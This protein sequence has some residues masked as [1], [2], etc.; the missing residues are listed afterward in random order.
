M[1][2][3]ELDIFSSSYSSERNTANIYKISNSF[4]TDNSIIQLSEVTVFDNDTN[5]YLKR[6]VYHVP[7]DISLFAMMP[8]SGTLSRQSLVDAVL[9]RRASQIA[10]MGFA[11]I[12][13]HPMDI[14]PYNSATDSWSNSIDDTKFQALKNIIAALEARG[15]GFSYM[16]D[17]TPAPFS[18][19]VFGP[20]QA[21]L[22]LLL[23]LNTITNVAWGVDVTV[24]GKLSHYA[25]GAAIQGATITF[26]GTGASNL[27]SATTNA[28]GI[29]PQLK[30]KLPQP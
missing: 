8:P 16:S 3:N 21:A 17:V 4:E 1:A 7:F 30:V 6:R 13:L 28:D 29:H 9:S 24:I 20:S 12:T 27:P 15:Y 11:V 18:E 19:V 25:T 14:A 26:N 23:T 22:L 2:E 5:Q 10:N